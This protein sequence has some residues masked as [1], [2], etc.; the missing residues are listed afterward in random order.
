MAPAG[1]A[2]SSGVRLRLSHALRIA[3][4]TIVPIAL[5]VVTGYFA[6]LLVGAERSCSDSLEVST[7]PFVCLTAFQIA[8]LAVAA[9]A[10]QL[11]VWLPLL[12]ISYGHLRW[13][14]RITG[15][16]AAGVVSSAAAGLVLMLEG[17]ANLATDVLFLGLPAAVGLLVTVGLP[18]FAQ[19]NNSLERSRER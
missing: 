2:L 19:P 8:A 6:M 16:A 9:T 10:L 17:N 14:K 12:V 4:V 3:G 11:L 1:G 13:R 15:L 5:A 18:W 7:A